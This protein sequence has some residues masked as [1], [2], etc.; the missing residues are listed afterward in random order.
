M[1]IS[2]GAVA[3]V[4]LLLFLVGFGSAGTMFYLHGWLLVMFVLCHWLLQTLYVKHRTAQG[5]MDHDREVA[6][7]L[8]SRQEG[9][10]LRGLFS[11]I[12]ILIAGLDYRFGWSSIPLTYSFAALG[13]VIFLTVLL[14]LTKGWWIDA[15]TALPT[16]QTP[17]PI[18]RFLPD[19]I[20]NVI[21]VLL[22]IMLGSWW[23]CIAFGC[24]IAYGI[25]ML[26]LVDRYM[27]ATYPGYA[28]FARMVPYRLIRGVW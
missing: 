9:A 17:I 10:D 6:L 12:G 25:Y 21:L 28:S 4:L 27:Q 14:M 2:F 19:L 13:V 7:F 26:N 22:G 15:L 3:L 1:H 16:I 8:A 18:V 5:V 24:E 20:Q 23:S 11:C